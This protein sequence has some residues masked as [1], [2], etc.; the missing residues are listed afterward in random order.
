MRR[1]RGA[2]EALPSARR[3]ARPVRPDSP[4]ELSALLEAGASDFIELP[5]RDFDVTDQRLARGRLAEKS[6]E[7]E[8]ANQQLRRLGEQQARMFQN[9][10][11]EL[12]TPLTLILSPLEDL[13]GSADL[14]DD[15]RARHGS[16]RRNALRLLGL[17]DGDP[18]GPTPA[19][20]RRALRRGAA[21]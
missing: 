19:D 20:R 13:L 6:A 18:H 17:I 14:D 4:A 8:V 12:R 3:R 11:H 2:A 9:V 5:L 10:T 1:A 15:A 7:L 21:R 16:M